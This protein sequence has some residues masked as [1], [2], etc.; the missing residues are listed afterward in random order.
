MHAVSLPF[1]SSVTY[2]YENEPVFIC[3]DTRPKSTVKH[4]KPKGKNEDLL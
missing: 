3:I 4:H 2:N 1:L